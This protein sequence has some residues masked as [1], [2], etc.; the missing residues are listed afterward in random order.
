MELSIR[1]ERQVIREICGGENDSAASMSAHASSNVCYGN[2]YIRSRLKLS[3]CARAM[4]D[5]RTRL[6]DR[7]GYD[8]A[9]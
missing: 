7:H 3:K 6:R 8:P 5:R 2:A 9:P 4:F 1:F